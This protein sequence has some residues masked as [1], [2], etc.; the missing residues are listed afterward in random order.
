MCGSQR[1]FKLAVGGAPPRARWQDPGI[2]A[3]LPVASEPEPRGVAFAQE[4]SP[5]Q[6]RVSKPKRCRSLNGV[7]RSQFEDVCAAW[8]HSLFVSRYLVQTL[9]YM[10][11]MCVCVCVCVCCVVQGRALLSP[12]LEDTGGQIHLFP[13][14]SRANLFLIYSSPLGLKYF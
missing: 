12:A 2:R 6:R 14:P 1:T 11:M 10:P 4:H 3:A 5:A 13:S 8:Y 9:I 7:V